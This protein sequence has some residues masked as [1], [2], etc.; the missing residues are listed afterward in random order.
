MVSIMKQ[1]LSLFIAAF[2]ATTALAQTATIKYVTQSGAG[3]KNGSNWA[4]AWNDSIFA[5]NLHLQTAGTAVWVAKGTYKPNYGASGSIGAPPSYTFSIPSGV[6]LYGGFAGN[7][8]TLADRQ[9]GLIHTTNKTILSGVLNTPEPFWNNRTGYVVSM[10]NCE[11][12]DGFTIS[13]GGVAGI[14]VTGSCS[15]NTPASAIN[16]CII[17]GNGGPAGDQSVGGIAVSLTGSFPVNIS[18]CFITGNRGALSGGITC[19]DGKL[20]LTNCVFAKN[21]GAIINF[22]GLSSAIYF[23]R[24]G[25]SV[26]N[27]TFVGNNTNPYSALFA[28]ENASD[29]IYINNTILWGNYD[30]FGGPQS[31]QTPYHLRVVTGSNRF[32]VKNSLYQ[33]VVVSQPGTIANTAPAVLL[34]SW[35]NNPFLV[36]ES[37]PAGADNQWATADDGLALTTCSPAVNVGNNAMASGVTKDIVGNNRLFGS[38][39]DLGAYELQQATAQG[40]NVLQQ[41]ANTTVNFEDIATFNVFATGGTIG[42]QWQRF[43]YDTGW[44]NLTNNAI[45]SG[46]TTMGLGVNTLHGVQSGAKYRCLINNQFCSGLQS[47][48]AALT[49]LPHNIVTL[50]PGESR[51]LTSFATGNVISFPP[52]IIISEWQV[53]TGSTGY[54]RIT[55]GPHYSGTGTTTLQIINPSS[56]WYGYKYRYISNLINQ[57]PQSPVYV[58]KFANRWTGG[59]NGNWENPANWSCGKVPD[60]NTDVTIG[61]TTIGGSTGPSNI[62]VGANSICRTLTVLPGGNTVTVLP[63]VTLTVVR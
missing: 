32:S 55:D 29:S 12:L 62:I 56:A 27:C 58:L 10:V 11:R 36:N 47:Q 5:A 28:S 25:G 43:V 63:G 34:N 15:G 19:S 21:V 49:I 54:H 61:T 20:N 7:E 24:S 33:P 9:P 50:C 3:L 2:F 38:Q 46:V 52:P 8:N 13:D 53:D 16:N 44:V 40:I 30:I 31:P 23:L 39:V 37:N 6:K 57:S 17:N 60:A 4:N 59:F 35:S 1:I 45:Y 51:T 42:Y 41:P 14:R 18:H 26:N 48:D 22:S